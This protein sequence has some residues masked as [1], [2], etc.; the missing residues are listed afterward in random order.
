MGSKSI[1]NICNVQPL[2]VSKMFSKQHFY[3]LKIDRPCY[4]MYSR[5]IYYKKG[6]KRLTWKRLYDMLIN[7]T[8]RKTN[9]SILRLI[10]IPTYS[11]HSI[12]KKREKV[13]NPIEI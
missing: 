4:T 2:Q 13:A 8:K 5:V 7:N 10:S 9:T 12:L 3:S 1:N 6:K 11:K